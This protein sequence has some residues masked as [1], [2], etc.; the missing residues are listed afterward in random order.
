[1]MNGD[2]AA[3]ARARLRRWLGLFFIALALPGAA[4]V[5]QAYDQLKWESFRIQQVAA[6]DL[7]G[8]VDARLAEL[9][10]TE[11]ARPVADYGFLAVGPAYPERRR[12]PLAD[13]PVHAGIPG[14][15]GW[16][17][18]AEDGRFSSPLVPEGEAAIG[19]PPAELDGRQALA[20][21]IAGV[22]IG[23][24]LVERDNG[25]VGVGGRPDGLPAGPTD[26]R[27]DQAR[28]GGLE[29]AQVAS[30]TP[31]RP[32]RERFSQQA[33]ERLG[34]QRAPPGVAF[35]E[36]ST[37]PT[38][39]QPGGVSKS[40][41][42]P[43]VPGS[44]LGRVDELTLDATLASR[45]VPDRQAP[46]A[47]PSPP[48]PGRGEPAA[49]RSLPQRALAETAPAKVRQ[50]KEEGVRAPLDLFTN[51]VEPCEL[52]LLDSGHFVLFRSVRSGG[53]RIIQ[54]LLI[55]QGPFLDGVLAGPFRA[56]PLARTTDLIVAFRDSVLAAFRAAPSQDYV[57]SP[58]E[59]TGALLYRT[60][61]REPFGGLEL[62]FSVGRLPVPAGAQ[63]IGWVGG[64]L[65]LV[66][67]TGT[68][69]IYRLSLGQIALVRQQQSFVSAV[70]HELRTPLTSIRLYAEML[71]AGF[72]DEGRRQVYYRYIQEESERLSRLIAN[73]LALSR[74]GRDA[75]T[76]SPQVMDLATLMALVQER[77]ASQVERAG[78]RL[79]LE[80]AAGGTVRADSDALVQVLINLVDNALKFAAEGAEKTVEIRGEPS[81]DGWVRIAVRDFGPGVPREQRRRV[82]QLFYR[83]PE[84]GARAIPGTGIGLALVERLTLAMGGRVE[85]VNREPGA[86]FRVELPAPP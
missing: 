69:L 25:Q 76:V 14:L 68:W 10:R 51:A 16:F 9:A 32:A 27:K 80:C 71:R 34:T 47:L 44:G 45:G 59:L 5:Y 1:M 26:D 41:G 36:E 73:V 81:R 52:G 2:N 23:N 77:V 75:L 48:R 28:M 29:K 13:F 50:T 43:S 8:R 39:S 35:D 3:Q 56:T 67:V 22:L 84:A 18:V 72:A 46:A 55:E 7:A 20:A 19:M 21:R 40:A 11:D 61:L 42:L 24:R 66:L 70:S 83:G 82:F 85:V 4:L 38:L 62:I 57:T 65:A 86:E 30:A 53:E 33:F 74:I 60:R 54:G 37:P 78:F 31:A 6:E 12:S 63:A 64:L 58:R 17:Q 49:A 79:V 15:M